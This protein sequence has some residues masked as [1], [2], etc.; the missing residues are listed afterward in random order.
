[1][2]ALEVFLIIFGVFMAIGAVLIVVALF[3]FY[4]TPIGGEFIIYTKGDEDNDS[5]YKIDLEEHPLNWKGN[6]IR[7]KI[8]RK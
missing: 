5:L 7:F 4:I 3:K 1:M 8:I 6:S 2:S